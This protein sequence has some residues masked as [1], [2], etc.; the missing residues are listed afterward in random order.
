MR[1]TWLLTLTNLNMFALPL[2]SQ[3]LIVI[4]ICPKINLIDKV[5]NIKDLGI[6]TSQ[7]VILTNTLIMF[8]SSV[9]A[10]RGGF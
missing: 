3:F 10:S 9:L 5:E 2:L 8:T 4:F 7:T 6:T 1:T